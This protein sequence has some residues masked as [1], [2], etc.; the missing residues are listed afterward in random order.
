[1]KAFW[2]PVAG[3]Q[4]TFDGVAAPLLYVS[5]T[6]IGCVVPFAIAGH[7]VTT[8]QVTYNGMASNAV[9]IPLQSLGMVPEVLGVYNA[10]FTRRWQ[11]TRS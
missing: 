11:R 2:L 7:T 5:S 10:D 1:M 3:V 4:M 9:P 6:E 8:M